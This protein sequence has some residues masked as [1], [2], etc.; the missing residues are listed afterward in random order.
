M[1]RK[2]GKTRFSCFLIDYK[3]DPKSG[4]LEYW[5]H[6]RAY[7]DYKTRNYSMFDY[8]YF[9]RFAYEEYWKNSESSYESF[10][11]FMDRRYLGK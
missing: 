7:Q 11:Q 8:L 5:E 10:D 4:K 2:L 6:F 1:K 3:I 9:L